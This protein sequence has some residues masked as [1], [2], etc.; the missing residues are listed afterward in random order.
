VA[1]VGIPSHFGRKDFLPVEPR[2]GLS[3]LFGLSEPRLIKITPLPCLAHVRSTPNPR[4]SSFCRALPYRGERRSERS[5]AR[6]PTA[7]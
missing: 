2:G 5:V 6:V 3:F 4:T 7:A 1:L